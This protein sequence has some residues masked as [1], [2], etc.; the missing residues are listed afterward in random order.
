MEAAQGS[1]LGT[2]SSGGGRRKNIL[3]EEKAG[4]LERPERRTVNAK[5][6]GFLGGGG[7]QC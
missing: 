1:P 2:V 6:E 3:A 5:Q 7:E 4:Q